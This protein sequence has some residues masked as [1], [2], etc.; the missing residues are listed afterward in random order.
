MVIPFR[1]KLWENLP[2]D[3]WKVRLEEFAGAWVQN[4]GRGGA[5]SSYLR[6]PAPARAYT[7]PTAGAGRQ[8]RYGLGTGG[9]RA[10][11]P[12]WQSWGTAR[13]HARASR[14]TTPVFILLRA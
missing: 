5:H 11:W 13:W 14:E 8:G 6:L 4:E 2:N 3:L 1:N 9:A 7:Y 12:A 10:A